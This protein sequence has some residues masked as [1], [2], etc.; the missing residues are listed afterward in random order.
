MTRSVSSSLLPVL[1]QQAGLKPLWPSAPA[2]V[3]VVR[4]QDGPRKLWFL[5]NHNEKAISLKSPPRGVDLIT[6]KRVPAVL[7]L[8]ARELA[9]IKQELR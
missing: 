3:E 4:R 9:I 7:H 1:A 2:G 6:G 5:I 8:K